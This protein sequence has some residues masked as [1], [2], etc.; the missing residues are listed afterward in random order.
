LEP[1]IHPPV[2]AR[3]PPR[4]AELRRAA[5][6]DEATFLRLERGWEIGQE[7]D[8]PGLRHAPDS[9]I[10]QA[11]ATIMLDLRPSP[12]AILAQVKPKCRYNTRLAERKGI[13]PDQPRALSHSVILA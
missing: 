8:I 12:E 4:L 9:A 6:A 7:P 10:V 5:A 2:A 13:D 3:W 1:K 11:P